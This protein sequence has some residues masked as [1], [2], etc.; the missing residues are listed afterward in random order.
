MTLRFFCGV[1]GISKR[2]GLASRGAGGGVDA[3]CV[4]FRLDGAPLEPLIALKIFT[5]SMVELRSFL[6]LRGAIPA[7][8]KALVRGRGEECQVMVVEC[9]W[10]E[11]R[12]ETCLPHTASSRLRTKFFPSTGLPPAFFFLKLHNHNP[13]R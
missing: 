1:T 12:V 9:A 5:E 10:R 2:F 4:V 7:R 3:P 11:A 8:S 6:F 13:P